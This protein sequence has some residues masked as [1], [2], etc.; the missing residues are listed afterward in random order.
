MPVK[1]YLRRHL[2]LTTRQIARLKFL[3]DGIRVNG[4][5]VTV[6]HTLREGNELCLL[7]APGVDRRDIR[8]GR[9]D[10]M[11]TQNA[12]VW[13]KPADGLPPFIVLYEDEDVLVADKPAGIPTHPSPGHFNDTLAN[14]AAAYLGLE[15][16]RDLHV[17]GR[18]DRDTSGVV[19][20]AKSSVA[21]AALFRQRAQGKLRKIYHALVVG[22]PSCAEGT[23]EL[24]LKKV[25]RSGADTI[26]NFMVVDPTG[27]KAV[28]HY[29]VLERREGETLLELWLEQGRMH[30]IRAHMAAIGCP[31]K[32]DVIYGGAK[33]PDLHLRAD[34]IAFDAPFPQPDGKIR[35]ICVE[36]K[37]VEKLEQRE[38]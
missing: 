35:R 33:K 12:A 23:V 20:F 28:T 8:E 38:V 14:Q 17:I 27:Q 26:E 29:R 21:A 25:T 34:S 37:E 6:R 18:L 36:A 1:M 15:R 24:P 31:V 10:L 19:L 32:G 3:E 11:P 4:E 2:H 9:D 7:A 22:T 30:Q 5:R 16:C 13:D